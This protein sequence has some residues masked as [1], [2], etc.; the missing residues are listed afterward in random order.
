MSDHSGEKVHKTESEHDSEII[1][2][3]TALERRMDRFD[4]L[5]PSLTD[6]IRDLKRDTAEIIE[7]F[8]LTKS[9]IKFF[10][11]LGKLFKYF[12]SI[13]AAGAALYA[14]FKGHSR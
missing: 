1:D 8:S 10:S 13:A 4:E 14:V 5:A 12:A 7:L 6:G 3:I 2:R 11:I 9:G